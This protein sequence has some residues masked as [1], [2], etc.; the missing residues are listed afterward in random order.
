MNKI[1]NIQTAIIPANSTTGE[2]IGVSLKFD[3]VTD[4]GKASCRVATGVDFSPH[5]SPKLWFE[6]FSIL[7][8]NYEELKKSKRFNT[9]FSDL[10]SNMIEEIEK[11]CLDNNW[12][13]W[14]TKV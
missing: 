11:V 10:R 2:G 6:S 7:D 12:V 8:V 14:S 4:Y 13:F 9:L 5:D 1:V 3:V